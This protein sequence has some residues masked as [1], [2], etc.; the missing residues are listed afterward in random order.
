[1]PGTG[2]E[3]PLAGPVLDT[4]QFFAIMGAFPTGV[5]IITTL[6]ADGQPRGLRDAARAQ[7]QLLFVG[8][9]TGHLGPGGADADEDRRRHAIGG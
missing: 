5:T 8:H 2:A 3:Q 7:R 6:D 9:R 4:A 1:V